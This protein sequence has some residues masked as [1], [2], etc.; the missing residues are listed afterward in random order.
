VMAMDTH[1]HTWDLA[2]TFGASVTLDPGLIALTMNM[3][4]PV[5]EMIRRPGVFAAKIDPPA[6]AD[7]QTKMLCFTDNETDVV[8]T[9][10]GQ[11]LYDRLTC[12]REFRRFLRAEGAE[13]HCEGMAPTV[14][15]TAAFDWLDST[16]V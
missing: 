1:A 12:P 6:D 7:E 16:L 4:G 13:G 9:G 15:W 14:L 10:Q 2:K 3:L 11:Q 8:S 5:D